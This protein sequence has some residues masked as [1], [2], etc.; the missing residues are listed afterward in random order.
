MGL[1]YD[2]LLRLSVCERLTSSVLFKQS[3]QSSVTLSDIYLLNGS[4]S[5]LQSIQTD[6]DANAIQ[7]V[8]RRASDPPATFLCRFGSPFVQHM[9]HLIQTRQMEDAAHLGF[10]HT[11]VYSNHDEDLHYDIRRA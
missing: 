5:R 10:L 7:L 11:F 3:A 9:A 1:E 4:V 2:G 8:L 6:P